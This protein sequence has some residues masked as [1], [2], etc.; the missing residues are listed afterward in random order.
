M[1]NMNMNNGQGQEKALDR[2]ARNLVRDARE[3]KLDP[4]IGRDEEERRCAR[5]LYGVPVALSQFGTFA[6]EIGG[7]ANDRT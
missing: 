1:Q 4:V 6:A 5:T 3:G 2:F 7:D